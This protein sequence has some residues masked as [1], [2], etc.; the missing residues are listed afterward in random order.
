MK[1]PCCRGQP[2]GSGYPVVHSLD[3]SKNS[4]I[5]LV[6]ILLYLCHIQEW[7]K[8]MFENGQFYL[9]TVEEWLS[10]ARYITL[11]KFFLKQQQQ[12]EK[13]P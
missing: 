8:V 2:A 10:V 5:L 9:I 13:T 6:L 3:P 7:A 11:T 4:S 1:T 12:Q